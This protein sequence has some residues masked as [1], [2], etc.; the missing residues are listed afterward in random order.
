[1]VKAIQELAD[2]ISG[3]AESITTAVLNAT[4]VHTDNLCVGSTCVTETQ[5]KAILTQTGQSPIT[6]TDVP[7]PT[8]P[9]ASQGTASDTS[10]TSTATTTD[11][12]ATTTNDTQATTTSDAATTTES[13]N[14]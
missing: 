2:K 1:M 3:L 6:I 7:A 9:E 8:S 13:S 4:T 11:S 12:T 14:Q 10:A 5:L